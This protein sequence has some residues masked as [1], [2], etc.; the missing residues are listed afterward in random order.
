MASDLNAEQRKSQDQPRDG[1]VVTGLE[2]NGPA[3]RAGLREGD[4]LLQL[5]SQPISSAAQFEGLVTKLDRKRTLVLLV[6]RGGEASY[7]PV[8]P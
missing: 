5:N 4:V 7:I 3:A 6:K 1:V 8:R 2:P